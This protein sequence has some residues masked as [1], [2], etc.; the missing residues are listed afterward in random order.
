VKVDIYS[1]VACPWCY[2]GKR[3]F[4]T[5]LAAFAGRE[6]VQVEWRPF[7]LDP[8]A[9]RQ[10]RPAAV[11]LAARYGGEERARVQMEHVTAAAAADGLELDLDN[12]LAANTFDAHRLLWW[13]REQG[14]EKAQ[15]VLAERLFAAHQAGTAD[16]GDVAVLARIAGEADL[17]GAADFLASGEGVE[18]VKEA[19]GEARAI[20]IESVPTFV[21]DSRW[22]VAGAQPAEIMLDL[23]EQVANATIGAAAE[24]GCCGGG[25]C[26]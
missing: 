7:Q 5:A 2:L 19:I 17:A 24:G 23:L 1:D 26:G 21:F 11:A 25:C 15:G 18:E 10:A 8:D 22:A 4:E 12:A 6:D 3:R 9:P 16:L 13:A 20:G 14:G